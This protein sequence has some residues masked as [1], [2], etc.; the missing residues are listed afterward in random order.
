MLACHDLQKS[1]PLRT[2]RLDVLKGVDLSVSPGECVVLKGGSGAGKTTLLTLLAGM[3][4]PDA[5]AVEMNGKNISQLSA[6]QRRACWQD[7]IGFVFQTFQLVPYLSALE[8]LLVAAATPAARERAESSLADLCLQPQLH[9]KPAQLSAGEQQRVAFA[10]AMVN[11][12]RLLLADEPTG[13]LD[14][15]SADVVLDLVQ[16]FRNAGR[17]VLLVSH[18]SQTDR[19]ADRVLHLVDGVLSESPAT[20]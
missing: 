2:S 20:V 19:V 18:H 15:H 16:E 3:M 9:S 13:N 8:N 6:R 11:S 10:R 5:G 4:R 14:A 1:F 7:D 12:P 17:A